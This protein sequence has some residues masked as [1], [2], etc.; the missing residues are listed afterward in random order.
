MIIV[1][2]VLHRPHTVFYV[3]LQKSSIQIQCIVIIIITNTELLSFFNPL[4]LLPL[5]VN[6]VDT[7][8]NKTVF[9]ISNF[10]FCFHLLLFMFVLFVGLHAVYACI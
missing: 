1:S 7:E 4:S 9:G 10:W 6:T 5:N 8:C 3:L 2:L